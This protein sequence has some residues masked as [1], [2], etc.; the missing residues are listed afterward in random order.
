MDNV[1]SL[2]ESLSIDDVLSHYGL[3]ELTTLVPIGPKLDNIKYVVLTCI[4]DV[5]KIPKNKGGVYFIA[6]NEPV[7]H[8]FHRHVLPEVLEDGSEIIYNGTAQDLRDRAKKHLL[9]MVSKGMSG[10]S[11]DILMNEDVESHTKCCYAPNNKKK[12][13]YIAKN[14]IKS[15]DDVMKL[16]L[17]EDEKCFITNN[18]KSTIYFRNGINVLDSKHS[19]YTYK[20]YFQEIDSHCVRDIV[21]T[22]WR[23]K[24]GI[25]K[26]CTYTEGR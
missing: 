1:C 18:T 12:T 19:P 24:N 3:T 22:T 14:P 8:T 23:K 7:H 21:E 2:F 10:I 16:A 26:L 17:S 5:E 11:L 4:E 20:F 13:P 25:P 9:R 6:T 15:L